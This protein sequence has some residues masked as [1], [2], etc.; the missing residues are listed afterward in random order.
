MR[1]LI[2]SINV[3]PDGFCSHTTVIADEELHEYAV[4]SLKNADIG[5]FGRV[6]YQLFESYWPLV[7]KN[8]T[9]SQP[10]I[11]FADAVDNID[12]IV[13][14]KTLKSADWKNTTIAR[15]IDKAEILK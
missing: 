1:K 5:L 12:K 6:T 14:S 11:E 13:F 10:E 7:A 15:E 3:T 2:A 8:R 4:D 9:D